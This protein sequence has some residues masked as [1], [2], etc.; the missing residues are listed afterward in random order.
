[1]TEHFWDR[2]DWLEVW[3]KVKSA[4]ILVIGT[5]LWLGEESSVCR[6]LIERLYGMSALLNDKGQSIYYG[7]V[8]GSVITGNEDGVKN[9]AMTICYAL[10]H[11]AIPSRRRPIAAGSE[12]RVRGCHMATKRTMEAALVM[13][14]NAFTQ[15]N[16][17]IMTWNLMHLARMLKT[18]GGYDNYGN[19][20]NAL[21]DGSHSGIENPD[22]RS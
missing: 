21:H 20:R 12:R 14:D 16:T 18:V 7:R 6:V 10:S 2:D 17:T 5:P 1:M 4:D 3:E 11:L 8:G 22:Y 13:S 9:A 19:D 15:R